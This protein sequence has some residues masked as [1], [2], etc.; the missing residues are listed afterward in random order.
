MNRRPCIVCGETCEIHAFDSCRLCYNRSRAE[1]RKAERRRHYQRHRAE[2]QAKNRAYYH[3]NRERCR[4]QQREY[5]NHETPSGLV[6]V[7]VNGW[8]YAG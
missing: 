1:Q 5:R 8:G 6:H 7:P 3:A 4:A 2:V